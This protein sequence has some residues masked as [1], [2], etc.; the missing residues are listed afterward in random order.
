MIRLVSWNVNGI[1]AAA[2]K[3]LF[4]WMAS[5]NADIVCLQETKAQPDQLD[6]KFFEVPGGYEH[7]WASAV[8]KGYS[9]TAIYTRI[10]P[11]SVALLGESAYDD[12]GR[13]LMADYGDFVLFNCYFPNSQDA[14]ARLDYKLG[15]CNALKK[16]TDE[17]VKTGKHIVV[18]GDY[19]IAHKPIDLAHPKAN[20]GNAGYLPEERAW[21]DEFTGAGYV[22]TFRSL[23]PEPKS[24]SWWSYRANARANNVGWRIDYFCT[25]AGLGSRIKEAL[26]HPDVHGSD[27]CPVSLELDF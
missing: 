23:H 25:D 16:K 5:C 12:E 27:H 20:E 8:K 15:F 21:M 9:G 24:Y 22:D 18:C 1:R 4:D 13:V 2:E 7:H 11:A 19:N 6:R 26:I 3:G 14:G 10:K 17:L